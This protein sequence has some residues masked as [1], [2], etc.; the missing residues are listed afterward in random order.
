MPDT[1]LSRIQARVVRTADRH[2]IAHYFMTGLARQSLQEFERLYAYSVKEFA[3]LSLINDFDSDAV[4]DWIDRHRYT[5]TSP[6]VKHLSLYAL[7]VVDE[8]PNK[9]N[10][11]LFSVETKVTESQET[12]A[13]GLASVF[14]KTGYS[15]AKY[16]RFREAKRIKFYYKHFTLI[17]DN[18]DGSRILPKLA[19]MVKED[20]SEKIMLHQAKLYRKITAHFFELETT[21]EIQKQIEGN[22]FKLRSVDQ[23]KS[24]LKSEKF[25]HILVI[26]I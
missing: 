13:A 24:F 1:T 7:E 18:R 25:I 4:A 14:L 8:V 22:H 17:N 19:K 2:Q 3:Y 23:L 9:E 6:A 15:L 20:C 11:Y 5:R 16:R 10:L 21:G 12:N 26:E